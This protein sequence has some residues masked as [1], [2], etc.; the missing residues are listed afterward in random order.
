[1]T[2]HP[3][4]AVWN[5]RK[6]TRHSVEDDVEHFCG[7][8]TLL[9]MIGYATT[10]A[11]KDLIAFTF[12]T[13][14]RISEIL[15]LK[16]D[17]FHVMKETK[18]PILI[19]RGMPLKKRY[20]KTSEYMECLKCHYKNPKGSINCEKCGG[21]LL[22]NGQRRFITEKLQKTRKEFAIRTDEPLTKIMIHTII[23]HLKKKQPYIFKNPYTGKPYTRQWAY[24]V[25]RKIGKKLG[26]YLYPHRLRSERACHLAN[27]LKAESL[28]EWFSWEDWKT[29]KRYAK[30]GALGL[31]REMGVEIPG[32]V[33]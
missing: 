17:M 27:S 8:A 2:R 16:T 23:K 6:Y 32:K 11:Q 3:E 19:V 28:L 4:K 20:K 13:G 25:L 26:L 29:G 7:W 15:Q 5:R 12:S 31:A 9:K 33:D 22:K 14:G 24:K 30:K 1:V 10:E 21:N 18:P